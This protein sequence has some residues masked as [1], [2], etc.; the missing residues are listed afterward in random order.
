VASRGRYR[1]PRI[2]AG[3]VCRRTSFAL[4][5]ISGNFVEKLGG[6]ASGIIQGNITKDIFLSFA[7]QSLSNNSFVTDP[8]PCAL[9]VPHRGVDCAAQQLA[10]FGRRNSGPGGKKVVVGIGPA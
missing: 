10:E 1:E 7:L 5:F 3:F 6:S 8:I 9:S 2:C 4:S